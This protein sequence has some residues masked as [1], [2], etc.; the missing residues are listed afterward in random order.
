MST[1]APLN[2]S[3]PTSAVSLS[4]TLISLIGLPLLGIVTAGLPLDR[5]L[6]FP[7]LTRHVRAAAFSWLVFLSMVACVLLVVGPIVY[8]VARSGRGKTINGPVVAARFPWWGWLGVAWLLMAW[9]LAWSRFDWF[10]PLQRHTFTPLWLGYI[11]IVN[12]LTWQR[13]G[14]CLLRDRPGFLALL[15]IVSALFWWYFE[16]LNRF[17]QNWHYAGIGTF[18]AGEYVLF[19][20][21]AF[22][23]VLPAVMSTRDLLATFP[24]LA[25]GLD[26]FLKIRPANPCRVASI[27]L[28]AGAIA[29]ANIGRWPDFLFPM[30]WLAP[31]LILVSI[32]VLRGEAHVFESIKDGNWRAVWLAGMAA[33]VCGVFWEMWNYGSLAHWEYTVPYVHRYQIFE[34]P[35]IGYAG[36]L[37]FGVECL[38][39][40]NC[41]SREQPK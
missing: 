34:M 27:I 23:T 7:P 32:Q 26:D 5:Y 12:A 16:F 17:V 39:V 10:A 11:V 1:C 29:L 41:L 37:L 19:A 28:V 22:S 24:R 36:Y 4:I 8:R 33:L 13:C 38:A 9:L 15:F 21:L 2:V 18:S 31:L 30:L 20:T 3:R 35:L 25:A 14:R 40:S 6:E